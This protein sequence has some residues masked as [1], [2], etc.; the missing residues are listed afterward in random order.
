[1][2]Y[3]FDMR[4][5]SIFLALVLLCLAVA[6]GISW[7]NRENIL[8]HFISRQLHVPVSISSLE[9]GKSSAK[10]S[11]LW[12]GNFPSSQTTTSFTSETLRVDAKW[13]QIFGNP[14]TIDHIDIDNIFVGIEFYDANGDDNNWG[15]MLHENGSKKKN[16]R[17]YLIRTLTLRN[18]TVEL[19]QANGKVK[20]YPT[21]KQMEFYN[22]SSATGFPV[23]EIEKAIFEMMMKDIFKKLQLDQLFKTINPLPIPFL[24]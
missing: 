19:T 2:G 23:E 14:V 24:K 18:L 5:F 6:I 9:I 21:I 7:T 1:M 22:I 20:R 16:P 12:I 4:K 15:R 8:A 10:I 17:D 3:L 11:R 13:D